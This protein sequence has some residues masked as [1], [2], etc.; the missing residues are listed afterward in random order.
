MKTSLKYALLFFLFSI[1]YG[2]S[3]GSELKGQFEAGCKDGL[4]V[5]LMNTSG[6]RLLSYTKG[7]TFQFDIQ[8]ANR[9]DMYIL[10]ADSIHQGYAFPLFLRSGSSMQVNI[11]RNF[12]EVHISGDTV[13]L[14]QNSFYTGLADAT[15]KFD[16]THKAAVYEVGSPKYTYIQTYYSNWIINHLQSPFSV[17]IIRSFMLGRDDK[18]KEVSRQL[19]ELVSAPAKTDNR[20]TDL[21][22]DQLSDYDESYS[23]VKVNDHIPDFQ[24]WDTTG[25]I[26][27]SD[28]FKGHLTLIDFWASWCGP[29]RAANI[30]L[31]PVYESYHSRG[32]EFLSISVD[33]SK[34]EWIKAIR[35]DRPSGNQICDFKGQYLVEDIKDSVG[36]LFG[37]AAVPQFYL[38]SK[39]GRVVYKSV[40]ANWEAL[41]KAIEDNL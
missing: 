37:I 6:V 24:G 35:K 33:T 22:K 30:D 9:W 3:R 2:V 31:Q 17:A 12:N 39:D 21:V 10:M 34:G 28:S 16:D 27:T 40:G 32:L 38:V 5:Y 25:S 36:W 29:C 20:Q 4:P 8:N 41:K 1:S 19:F 14:E 7:G 23:K 11:P 13:S 26:I 15:K 18:S